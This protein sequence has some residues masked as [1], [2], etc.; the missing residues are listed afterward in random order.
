MPVAIA[1]P[2]TDWLRQLLLDRGFLA[3]IRGEAI[4]VYLVLLAEAGGS[5]NQNVTLS[6]PQITQ[7]TRLSQP[8]VSHGLAHLESLGLIVAVERA[9]GKVRTYHL[10]D[11]PGPRQAVLD[12][13]SAEAG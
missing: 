3:L 8:T 5:P 12:P 6:I 1:E 11:P 9:V 4:K 7:R 10:L 13:V 2:P